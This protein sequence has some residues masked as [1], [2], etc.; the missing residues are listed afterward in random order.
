MLG[1]AGIA[2]LAWEAPRL[3]CAHLARRGGEAK[4]PST[5]AE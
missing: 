4:A 2:Y 1:G 3:W 5:P